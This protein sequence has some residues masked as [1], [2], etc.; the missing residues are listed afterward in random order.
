MTNSMSSNCG[1]NGFEGGGKNLPS[2]Q[3][4][5]WRD[6]GRIDPWGSSGG[7]STSS[8]RRSVADD[9]GEGSHCRGSWFWQDSDAKSRRRYIGARAA[10]E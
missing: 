8:Q 4:H 9:Y 7:K 5:S 3:L 2:R 10:C 1:M 6:Y